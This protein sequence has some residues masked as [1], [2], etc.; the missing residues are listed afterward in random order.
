MKRLLQ[1]DEAAEH[2]RHVLLPDL[3]LLVQL[4]PLRS[5]E[6]PVDRPR[7]ENTARTLVHLG[8]YGF[9]PHDW[10]QQSQ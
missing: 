3:E 2:L 4:L 6:C 5:A 10:Q 7:D 1:V 9:R 8:V